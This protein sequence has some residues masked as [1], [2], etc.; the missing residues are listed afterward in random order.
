MP[1]IKRKQHTLLDF[2]QPK[3]AG[4]GLFIYYCMYKFDLVKNG[5]W[6]PSIMSRNDMLTKL[7]YT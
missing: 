1:D 7:W 4:I 6:Y 2:P 3:G 5:T